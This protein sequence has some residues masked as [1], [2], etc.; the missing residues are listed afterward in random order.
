MKNILFWNTSTCDMN[1][2]TTCTT[3]YQAERLNKALQEENGKQDKAVKSDFQLFDI[4]R[5]FA[6]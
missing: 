5:V 4:D 3:E 1:H 2:N 6:N